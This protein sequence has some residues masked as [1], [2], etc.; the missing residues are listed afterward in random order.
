M[1]TIS[2]PKYVRKITGTGDA[3]K[4]TAL[5]Q[6]AATDTDVVEI[7]LDGRFIINDFIDMGAPDVSITGNASQGKSLIGLPSSIIEIGFENPN[8]GQ[9]AAASDTSTGLINWKSGQATRLGTLDPATGN[10]GSENIT[11]GGG[12]PLGLAAGEIVHIVSTNTESQVPD[13]TNAKLVNLRRVSHNNKIVGGLDEDFSTGTVGIWHVEP[14]SNVTIAGLTFSN[15]NGYRF[16]CMH[17][18]HTGGGDPAVGAIPNYWGGIRDSVVQDCRALNGVRGSLMGIANCQD[19]L[20][21]NLQTVGDGTL[22]AYEYYGIVITSGDKNLVFDGCSIHDKRHPFTTTGIVGCE[23]I[24]IKNGF[25]STAGTAGLDTHSQGK[26]VVFD[27]CNINVQQ[28]FDI[29]AFQAA[30]VAFQIRNRDSVIRNCHVRSNGISVQ[31]SEC[32]IENNIIENTTGTGIAITN[33]TGTQD[34]QNTVIQN[35]L[36]RNCGSN[37]FG[38]DADFDGAGTIVRGNHFDSCVMDV[39]L[40]GNL[41]YCAIQDSVNYMHNSFR[42]SPANDLQGI[43]FMDEGAGG[44]SGHYIAFNSFDSNGTNV[45]VDAAVTGSPEYDASNVT[46]N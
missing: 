7:Q 2:S 24:L 29:P 32:L 17:F 23:D 34:I 28:D 10:L 27:S 13:P 33:G 36:I 11:Y 14:W 15:P 30:R 21:K 43:R 31:A 3:A 45:V 18:G 42:A 19:V 37:G 25:F 8:A 16:H 20:F 46:F 9:I 41:I 40:G 5:L 12:N 1:L 6:D 35:N 26:R 39:S 44:A 38:M 22:D 4:D